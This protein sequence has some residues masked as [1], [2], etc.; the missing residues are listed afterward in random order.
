M[1]QATVSVSISPREK[2]VLCGFLVQNAKAK[3]PVEER[4]LV[5]VFDEFGLSDLIQQLD[6]KNIWGESTERGPLDVSSASLAFVVEALNAD[7]AK[8]PLQALV[9]RPL[10]DR[11][12]KAQAN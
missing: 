8:A 9:L 11:L 5:N 3:G 4:N 7:A 2:L 1:P 12:S 6:S 10:A